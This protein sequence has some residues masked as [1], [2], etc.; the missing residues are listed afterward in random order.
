MIRFFSRSLT[1]SPQAIP[2]LINLHHNGSLPLEKVVK[3]Y[4]FEDFSQAFDD[5]QSGLAIKPVL[6]FD[7]GDH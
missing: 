7:D 5:M 3:Y 1:Y 4:K 6:V 2:Y